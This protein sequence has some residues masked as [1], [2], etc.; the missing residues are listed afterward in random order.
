MNAYQFAA[1]QAAREEQEEWEACE[2]NEEE[3]IDTLPGFW[4]VGVGGIDDGEEG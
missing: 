3:E 1:F 2:E 4:E